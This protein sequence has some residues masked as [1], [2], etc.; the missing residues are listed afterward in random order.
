[1]LETYKYCEHNGIIRDLLKCLIELRDSSGDEEKYISE[2][3][4]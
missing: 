4:F 2:E 3:I 1:M